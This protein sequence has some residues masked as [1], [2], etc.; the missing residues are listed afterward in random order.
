MMSD[1]RKSKPMIVD[2]KFRFIVKIPCLMLRF[3]RIRKSTFI[4]FNGEVENTNLKWKFWKGSFA[5]E[6]VTDA[7]ILKEW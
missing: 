4:S 3:E 7:Y 5:V 2:K 6:N 1:D